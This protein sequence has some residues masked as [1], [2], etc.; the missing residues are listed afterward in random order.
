MVKENRHLDLCR[1]VKTILDE[2]IGND[3]M[4]LHALVFFL[5]QTP[6]LVEDLPRD[7]KFAQIMQKGCRD[8]L[9]HLFF[10]HVHFHADHTA[11]NT[12]IHGMCIGIIV[13]GTQI[14]HIQRNPSLGKDLFDQLFCHDL[15]AVNISFFDAI[16]ALRTQLRRNGILHL[17]VLCQFILDVDTRIAVFDQFFDVIVRQQD[18]TANQRS[19]ITII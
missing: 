8:Q 14:Q 18:M 9:C 1:K 17:N 12:Y 5:G 2:F 6:R 10:I 16:H 19:P 15:A 4:L 7:G 11:Q 3:R 13:I